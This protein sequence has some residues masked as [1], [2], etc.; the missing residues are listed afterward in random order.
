MA[1]PP[2][3]VEL[4]ADFKAYH[5]RVTKNLAAVPKTCGHLASQDLSF[6]R[7][8]SD[9]VSK[10][11]DQQT[12]HLLRLTN[13]L[14][15]FAA[16]DTNVPAPSLK[17]IDSIDDDWSKTVDLVDDVLE[18]ADASL[19]EFTG[20]IKRMSPA[21]QNTPPPTKAQMPPKPY[22]RFPKVTEKPQTLFNRQVNNFDTQPFKPLLIHKPHAVKSLEESIGDG[23]DG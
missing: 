20:V 3:V 12:A 2:D 16:K 8:S 17:D 5:E 13:K 14:L 18:K 19:D 10:S 23:I 15:K 7:S 22:A 9:K 6:H 21:A 11:L 1:T 4:S